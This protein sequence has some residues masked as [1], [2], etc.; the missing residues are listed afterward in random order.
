MLA[1][2]SPKSSFR[3]IGFTLLALFLLR[4]GNEIPL[5]G[6]DQYA[7][8]Q[9]FQLFQQ[10][11]GIFQILS[12]Y[13]GNGGK[14]FFTPFSLGIIPF[15]NASI[16]VDVLT[17]VIPQLEELQNEGENGKE[18]LFFYKKLLT[19]LFSIV[20]SCFLFFSVK[21]Y[22]YQSDSFYFS[23]FLLELVTGTMMTVWL[24]TL[25]EKEGIGN[26]TSVIILTN[27]IVGFFNRQSVWNWIERKDQNWIEIAVFIFILIGICISQTARVNI[28]LL[29]ARQLTFLEKD[30]KNFNKST[31]FFSGK[32]KGLT[33]RLN[34][35][36]IFP[37]IIA[38][39]LL[40]FFSYS[41]SFFNIP[42]IIS[43]IVY[44]FLILGFNYFYTFVFWDPQ[45]IADQL[46]KASVS[47]ANITP[48]KETVN[49]LNQV[50]QSVS[51]TGGILLC[52]ILILYQFLQTLFPEFN[53][54]NLSSLIILIGIA[55]EIQKT[56]R[57]LSK[58]KN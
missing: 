3:K 27:I 30:K 11:N 43:I 22:L 18:K 26:G 38:S 34:Q 23:L 37:I 2:F 13:S 1:I 56:L 44:Y 7:L 9:S 52:F 28:K 20:Q 39:N 8:K 10:N 4:L 40:P 48:G 51:L 45:K 5:S 53:Q 47:I 57:I 32:E 58:T 19:L 42:K 46:R 6:V 36:G 15:I 50:V 31:T 24:T 29:S 16:L 49:Y 55:Y 54:I 41:F 14:V 25:I 17:T 12:M 21:P 35:A 33:L